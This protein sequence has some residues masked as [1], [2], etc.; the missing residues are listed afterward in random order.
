[1]ARLTII[2]IGHK[3]LEQRAKEAIASARAILG[4]RRL[5]EVFA[6]YGEFEKAKERLT[7]IDSVDETMRFIREAFSAGAE[8]LVLL[9]SGDPLF[10][11]IGRR[12]VEEFGRDAVEIIPDLSSLQAAFSRAKEAWDDALFVSLHAGPDPV[13]R[14]RLRYDLADI[15][16]LL[17]AYPTIGI[18][19][20]RENSP[21]VI[22]S[23]LCEPGRSAPSLLLYVGERMG[24]PDE[25]VVAGTPEE[26]ARQSFEEP[27][28]LIVKR[29]AAT[30]SDALLERQP[31]FGLREEEIRHS[32]GLITKD[33]VRAVSIH[34]LRLPQ[35]GVLWDIGSGSGAVSLEAG[36]LSPYLKVYSVERNEEQIR[37]MKENRSLFAVWNMTVVAGAAPGVLGSLPTPDRVFIGGTGGKTREVIDAVSQ[38]MKGGIVVINAATLET[39]DRSVTSLEKN[40]FQVKISQVSVARTKKLGPGRLLAAQNPVFV[41]T[42]ERQT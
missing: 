40:G 11:G 20:D 30:A 37:H 38:R 31:Q 28:V 27:N 26:I 10:F 8:E 23:F 25:R 12:A 13:K 17:D 41:V 5:C 7:R 6:R 18:L 35:E 33:E 21:S 9:G 36:R 14:R 34:A 24:Y 32:R 2:G 42:G 16:R 4:S 29:T 39:L 19:T 15:P 3:P 22:A 1:M